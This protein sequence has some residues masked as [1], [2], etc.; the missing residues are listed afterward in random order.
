MT[1]QVPLIIEIRVV[2]SHVIE[3]VWNGVFCGKTLTTG[4]IS[5]VNRFVVEMSNGQFNL[6]VVYDC[7]LLTMQNSLLLCM[8]HLATHA[9]SK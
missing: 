5:L 1:H 7:S 4:M 6:F 8:Q 2:E 3:T 9:V